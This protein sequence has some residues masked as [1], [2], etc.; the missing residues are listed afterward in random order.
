MAIKTSEYKIHSK[1]IKS[2]CR[3]ALVSD[4]HAGAPDEVIEILKRT[5][6]DYILLAGDIFERLDGSLDEK[7]DRAFAL[8]FEAAKIAPAF[9]CTGNHEDGE[10][11][12]WW[13]LWRRKQVRAREYSEENRQRI[14]ASGVVYLEDSFTFLDGIAFGGLAS[15]LIYEGGVPNMVWLE[16]F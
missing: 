8:L 12:A 10:R 5:A 6:P 4:L 2:G 3:R 11:G 7:N 1:K 15:G 9:Y 16:K 13:K 14:A